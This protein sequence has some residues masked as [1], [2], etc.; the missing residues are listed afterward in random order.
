MS[1]TPA[2]AYLVEFGGD[3]DV[4]R[5]PTFVPLARASGRSTAEAA[6]HGIEAVRASGYASGE[7]AARAELEA[8]LAELRQAHGRQL[9]A[10]RRAWVN[11]EAEKLDQRLAS[12]LAELEA[13]IAQTAARVLEPFLRAEL[14]RQAIA[15]LH[16]ALETLLAKEGGLSVTVGGPEDLL[17]ALRERLAGGLAGKAASV[18][19]EVNAEPDVRIAA[20]HSILETRLGAWVAKIE[21]AVE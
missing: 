2:A 7:A 21:G 5:R 18:S 13:S 8:E 1:A 12:G 4:E 17:Q 14:R 20:G 3:G 11:G 6:S 9:A 15:D 19:Y 10:E 16:S